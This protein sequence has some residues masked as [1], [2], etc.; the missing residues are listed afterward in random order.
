MFFYSSSPSPSCMW[1]N[2]RFLKEKKITATH[3]RPQYRMSEMLFERVVC[4]IIDDENSITFTTRREEIKNCKKR[5]GE[6]KE[7]YLRNGTRQRETLSAKVRGR[8]KQMKIKNLHKL[9]LFF[10]TILFLWKHVFLNSFFWDAIREN[11]KEST[12]RLKGR[13]Y[14]KKK[15]IWSIYLKVV[16]LFTQIVQRFCLS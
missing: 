8:R 10:L 14:L 11:G 4:V 3:Q 2:R 12:N 9:Q 1:Q 6:G 15:V 5:G 7:K 13:K 16:R